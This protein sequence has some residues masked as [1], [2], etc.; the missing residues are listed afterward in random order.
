MSKVFSRSRRQTI[1]SFSMRSWARRT[2][3]WYGRNFS[4]LSKGKRIRP[5]IARRPLLLSLRVEKAALP[6]ARGPVVTA[7]D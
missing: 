3:V 7:D 6:C 5:S 1:W 2:S 4:S